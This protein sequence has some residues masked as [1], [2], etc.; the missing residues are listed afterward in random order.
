VWVWAFPLPASGQP[1]EVQISNNGG[2]TPRWSRNGGELLYSEGDRIMKVRYSVKGDQFFPE[3]PEV[4]LEGPR[5][6]WDLAPDGRLAVVM[7]VDA[8]QAAADHQVVFLLNF[9]D[10]LKRRVK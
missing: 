8:S 10:E 2:T 6:G 4:R 1:P 3:K 5:I 9:F 7:P